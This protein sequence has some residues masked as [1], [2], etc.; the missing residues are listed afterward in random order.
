[1]K[2]AYGTRSL[3]LG[4]GLGAATCLG[5]LLGCVHLHLRSWHD[6]LQQPNRHLHAAS[7]GAGQVVPHRYERDGAGLS[8]VG[9]AARG[10]A[11]HGTGSVQNTSGRNK[12]SA[13]TRSICIGAAL[14]TLL[15]ACTMADWS[16]HF[17]VSQGAGI[18][19]HNRPFNDFEEDITT[20][21]VGLT[22][23]PGVGERHDETIDA[24]ERIEYATLYHAPLPQ[25]VVQDSAEADDEHW[26]IA[27]PPETE[28]EGR[29]LAWYG[30]YVLLVALALLPLVWAWKSGLPIPF[31]PK[32]KAKKEDEE[33]E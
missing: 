20:L 5:H 24:M 31:L 15:A 18:L 9:G 2:A 8:Q 25:P 4:E 28:E 7:G 1:M 14:V 17:G 13:W 19:A 26:P 10:A 27:G 32:Y 16:F 23:S 30:V 11:A 6:V 12:Y 29:A 3:L 22:Y 21:G 33:A